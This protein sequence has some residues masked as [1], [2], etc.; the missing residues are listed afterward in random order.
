MTSESVGSRRPRVQRGTDSGQAV[1]AS[2]RDGLIPGTSRTARRMLTAT[3]ANARVPSLRSPRL[4]RHARL[5]RFGVEQWN[6]PRRFHGQSCRPD[7]V[8]E[9]GRVLHEWRLVSFGLPARR[10]RALVSC[11]G[12]PRHRE[13]T[14][15]PPR[16]R[17]AAARDRLRTVLRGRCRLRADRRHDESVLPRLHDRG[18][19]QVGRREVHGRPREV[20]RFVQGRRR[21]VSG[22]RVCDVRGCVQGRKVPSR[23]VR[24][25]MS[26]RRCG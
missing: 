4:A 17:P 26:R 7:R 5:R 16:R 15:L 3:H 18:D 20:P 14:L 24:A 9:S 2:L 12:G 22:A 25:D 10:R 6:A 13:P 8:R 23:G 1:P 19:R 11:R 21:A